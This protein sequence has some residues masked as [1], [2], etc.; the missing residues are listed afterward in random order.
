MIS[1]DFPENVVESLGGVE[2]FTTWVTSAVNDEICLRAGR[3][4]I[5]IPLMPRPGAGQSGPTG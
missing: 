2:H 4:F 5:G 3:M 1:I